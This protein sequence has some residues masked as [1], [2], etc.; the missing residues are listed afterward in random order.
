MALAGRLLLIGGLLA[1]CTTGAP[2]D[3]GAE[4]M[5]ARAAGGAPGCHLEEVARLPVSL[6]RGFVLVPGRIDEKPVALVVDTGAQTSL[7]IP[8]AVSRLHLRPDPAR[9]TVV[10]GTGGAVRS[11]NVLVNSFDVGG[12]ALPDQSFPVGQLSGVYRTEPPLAGLLGADFLNDYDLE[13]DIPERRLTLYHAERCVGGFLPWHGAY[14]A[15]RLQRTP[16]A[17]LRLPVLVD[18]RRV[19]ALVDWGAR[20][21][22]MS[23]ETA[24]TLGL[25]QA[26]LAH[27]PSSV[28]HGV[29]MNEIIG[30]SHRFHS[31]S[32]GAET[33]HDW[34]MIIANLRLPSVGMLLGADYA[35][36]RRIW[37]SY[38]KRR[39]YVQ[40]EHVAVGGA[41]GGAS[42]PSVVAALDGAKFGGVIPLGE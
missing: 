12:L 32:V 31:V 22:A 39:M 40:P 18:G 36:T 17:L 28:S 42:A 11:Q 15:V 20:V 30:Y 4:L 37:L 26:M 8:D 35:Q 7:L 34:A 6:D 2:Y 29:D 33:F 16:E 19:L 3:G 21:S 5:P 38:G 1:G 23:L 13:L 14:F 41:P 9:S 25:S 10:Q 27:D 24:G